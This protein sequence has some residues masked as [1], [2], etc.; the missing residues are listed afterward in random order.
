MKE[1]KQDYDRIK[2]Y[3]KFYHIRDLIDWKNS[4]IKKEL[5]NTEL[6]QLINN[7]I[8]NRDQDEDSIIKNK[9]FAIIDSLMIK[10]KVNHNFIESILSILP[11]IWRLYRKNGCFDN[12]ELELI[13]YKFDEK[14]QEIEK[15]ILLYLDYLSKQYDDGKVYTLLSGISDKWRLYKTEEDIK[16]RKK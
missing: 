14:K 8:N 9:F 11:D 10:Y 4:M 16:E 7:E 5:T 6:Y 15:E 3:I 12:K 1:N 2:K 13:G